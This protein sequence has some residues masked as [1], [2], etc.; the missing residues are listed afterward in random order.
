MMD[1]DGTR[2]I[3]LALLR[4]ERVRVELEAWPAVVSL[5]RQHGLAA[6]LFARARSEGIYIPTESMSALRTVYLQNT[7][8]NMLL[9]HQLA[10]LLR[11]YADAGIDVIALKGAYLAEQVYGDIAVRQ[12]GD[13]DLLIRMA[14]I[15]TARTLLINQ[16]FVGATPLKE[17]VDEAHHLVFR[18]T[19][20][21]LLVEVHWGLVSAA[22]GLQIDLNGV[23]QRACPAQV[24]NCLVYALSPEDQILHLCVHAS[25]HGFEFGLRGLCDIAAALRYYQ[26]RVDWEVLRQRAEQWK[27]ERCE[28]ICLRLAEELLAAP[29]A[30]NW[31]DAFRPD[32][33]DEHYLA[34]AREH[35]FESVEETA[36]A[37]PRDFNIAMLKMETRLSSKFAIL[38]HR[39]FPKRSEMAMMYP[40]SPRS[41]RML[42]YYLVRIRDLFRRHGRVVWHL[43]RGDPQMAARAARQNEINALKQWLL[44][45]K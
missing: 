8:Q 3:L 44:S 34:L 17:V 38:W 29:V 39:L 6:L 35:M 19:Q 23:W 28:Y 14:D 25:A 45:G 43:L 1:R 9:Y 12:M 16:G 7:G 20:T 42:W 21:G 15:P 13:V 31:L 37:L 26:I 24:A 18:H 40:A 36:S 10:S 22:R 2:G 41:P 32:D 30:K 5:A 11:A 33:R 27:A 4:S